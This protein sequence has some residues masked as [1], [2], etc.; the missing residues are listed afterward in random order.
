MM[1]EERHFKC[2]KY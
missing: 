2:G 1:G